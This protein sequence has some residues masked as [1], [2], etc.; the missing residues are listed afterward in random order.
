MNE[1]Q[2][3]TAPAAS[4]P[5][6]PYYPGH[7]D[8]QLMPAPINQMPTI[9]IPSTSPHP[10]AEEQDAAEYVEESLSLDDV[11]RELIKKALEK[12]HGKRKSAAK[13]LNISERTLY[14]KLKEYGLE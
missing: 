14:R 11:E 12:N 7:P 6:V 8:V 13:D 9:S 2:P 1:R 3:G 10:S 4:T 5:S